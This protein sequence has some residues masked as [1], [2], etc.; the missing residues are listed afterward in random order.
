MT[1]EDGHPLEDE[2][3]SGMTLCTI[4]VKNFEPRTE[5][6]RHHAHETI[7]EYVQKA[8]D[9]IQWE[10]V[11]REFDEMI[12]TKKESAPGPDGFPNGIC[13][14]AG[15]LGFHFLFNAYKRALEGGVVPTHFA[16]SRPCSFPSPPM[17]MTMV[18]IVRSPDALRPLTL[19][20]CECKI[21]TTAIC[22]GLHW[23]SIRCIHSAKGASR[24]GK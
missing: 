6:E 7:L 3:E 17:S 11:K 4:W 18:F 19:C 23:Y 10:T 24:P 5:G 15:G 20:N 22:F 12:V 8:L 2:D 16:A 9:D 1:D 14:C 21:I 13:R